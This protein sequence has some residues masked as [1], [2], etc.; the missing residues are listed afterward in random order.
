MALR[1]A[2]VDHDENQPC[3]TGG[4]SMSFS[5][6]TDEDVEVEGETDVAVACSPHLA[7][8]FRNCSPMRDFNV[9]VTATCV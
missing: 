7:R 5:S 6:D 1:A 8:R 9:T 2:D 3:L 4:A